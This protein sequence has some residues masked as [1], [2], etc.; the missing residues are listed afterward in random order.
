MIVDPG[1]FNSSS[2]KKHVASKPMLVCISDALENLR[3]DDFCAINTPGTKIFVGDGPY[4]PILKARYGD[5]IFVKPKCGVSLAHYYANADV[6]ICPNGLQGSPRTIAE[7]ICCGSPVAARPNE[8]TD[9]LI[10]K[11]V[12]GEICDNLYQAIESCLAMERTTIEQIGHILFT[13]ENNLISHL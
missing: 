5:V 11:H 8:I 13:K 9:D 12:T 4:L 6:V 2:R 3:I 10:I 7:A 1:I